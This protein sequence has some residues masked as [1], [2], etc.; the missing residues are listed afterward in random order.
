MYLLLNNANIHDIALESFSIYGLVFNPVSVSIDGVDRIF[1]KFRD[2]LSVV[3]SQAN[4]CIDA[5]F[6]VERA[7][8]FDGVSF[9]RAKQ[10]VDIV[11]KRRV[12]LKKCQVEGFV[13]LAMLLVVE[14]RG[15]RQSQQVFDLSGVQLSGYQLGKRVE[16]LD[17]DRAE[18]E[19]LTHVLIFNIVSRMQSGACA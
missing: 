1:K 13:E 18:F 4:Q 16:S 5:E 10:G 14:S 12:N 6:V 17:V 2:F 9:F 19:K 8:R 15:A 7:G 3:D 11:D